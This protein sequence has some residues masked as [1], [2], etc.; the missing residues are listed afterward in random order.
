MSLEKHQPA[1][2]NQAKQQFED[3][4][5]KAKK[6]AGNGDTVIKPVGY[7]M[8]GGIPHKFKEGK[9]IPLTRIN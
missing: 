5:A 3:A 2:Y 1:N 8:R 4:L 7:V 9:W 6:I